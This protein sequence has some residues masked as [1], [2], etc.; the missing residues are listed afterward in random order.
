L[1]PLQLPEAV[2]AIVLVALHVSVEVPPLL[3]VLGFAVRLT[4]GD[5]AVTDTVTD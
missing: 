2:Q 1:A 3:I 5:A 4:L